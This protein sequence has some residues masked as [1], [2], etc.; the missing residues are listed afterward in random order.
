M[1][2]PN[3]SN[4]MPVS[5][6]SVV[7][8]A[9]QQKTFKGN[10]VCRWS[11]PFNAIPFFDPHSSY[12]QVQARCSPRN[13][14]TLTDKWQLNGNSS[15]VIKYIKFSVNGIVLEE[16][17]EYNCLAQVYSDYGEDESSRS[18]SAVFNSDS[19]DSFTT[20]L[21][22]QATGAVLADAQSAMVKTTKL[23]IPLKE[24]AL[25]GQL[26]VVPLMAFGSNLD[27]E[28]RFA[29][30]SEVLMTYQRGSVV[31]RYSQ[32]KDSAGTDE[33]G[34]NNASNDLANV[35]QSTQ[36]PYGQ[37]PKNNDSTEM[38]TSVVPAQNGG[39]AIQQVLTLQQPYCGFTSCGDIPLVVGQHVQVLAV[40]QRAT[41][42]TGS[43]ILVDVPTSGGTEMADLVIESITQGAITNNSDANVIVVTLTGTQ[44]ITN[45]T[46]NLGGGTEYKNLLIRKIQD[47][48]GNTTFTNANANVPE[49]E[50]SR[51]ELYLQKVE[52]PQQYVEALGRSVQSSEGFQYDLHT[53]T[54]YKSNLHSA[55]SSQTIEI[56]AFQSRAKSVLCVP[57]LANQPV[58]WNI[59]NSD[60]NNSHYSQRGVFGGLRDY[61]WQV[62]NG[63]RQ[64]TRPVNLDVMSGTFKHLSA[65]HLI[66]L[67]QA[68]GASNLGVKSLKEARNDFVIGRQLSK[69]GAT[70]NLNSAMRCYVNYQTTTQPTQPL[71]T[72]TFLNHI[73]RVSISSGGL[74]VFN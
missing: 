29:D 54:T 71:Q 15:V 10:N 65:E 51:C 72:I 73:N 66:Q 55:I 45:P 32:L 7:Q 12:L 4:E 37:L 61:Q 38:L 68:L 59:D 56:P 33:A 9:T 26:S 11:V 19:Q 60:T 44:D 42:A 18:H 46:D 14:S 74:Q 27:I 53:F 47:T 2:N 41:G 17:D 3:S 39:G 23:L 8:P 58:V 6:Y 20:G 67:S 57:R 24:T 34:G 64:P 63:L 70:T 62:N 28:I 36:L 49:M 25:F 21:M 69:Y 43:P 35:A 13:G 16:I 30:D 31:D 1:L 52:P 5:N 48:G 40:D 50:Y 22:G